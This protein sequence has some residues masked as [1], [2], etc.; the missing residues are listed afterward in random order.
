MELYDIIT[1]DD[2]KDYSLVK[3]EE[4]QGETYCM[5]IEVDQE[6]NPLDDFLILR[7]VPLNDSE[8]EF[9]E[10]GM[11]EYKTISEIFKEQFLEDEEEAA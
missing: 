1:L 3:M 7:K 4:Y 6:E 2:N 11:E 10:L 8:F 5:L 9:E